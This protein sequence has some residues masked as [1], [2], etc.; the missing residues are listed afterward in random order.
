M[1][2]AGIIH[3]D[4]F[5]PDLPGNGQ[6]FR[7]KS[8][9]SIAAMVEHLRAEVQHRQVTPPYQLLA[10]SLGGMVA[11][12]WA[13]MYPNEIA[14]LVLINTS[15]RPLNPWYRRLRLGSYATLLRIASAGAD[16]PKREALILGLTSNAASERSA[17]LQQ[18]VAWRNE[19]PVSGGNAL[20]QIAAAWIY[21]AS[22]AVPP[23]PVLILASAADRLVDVR[24]S[25]QLA[26]RWGCAL[27]V[28]PS[29]GHDLP[30]DDGP[31]VVAQV[32]E[33]LQQG[34]Q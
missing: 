1:M 23:V 3:A 4:V 20:R 34:L 31:W 16:A 24:C 28:H 33:W 32:G 9:T 6:L 13:E 19:C 15:L 27:A 22:P 29:A 2:T 21:R 10:L 18:W 14:A 11:V 8:P 5:A 7:V 26:K 30:L 25:R 17:I 12:A